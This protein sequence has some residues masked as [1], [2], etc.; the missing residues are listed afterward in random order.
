V[1]LSDFCR[2][3]ILCRAPNYVFAVSTFFAVRR[4][5]FYRAMFFAVRPILQIHGKGIFAVHSRMA[6]ARR[7]ATAFFPVVRVP[8]AQKV[9]QN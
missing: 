1:C 6:K 3:F 5:Q 4:Q 9:N 7:T 8:L 2:D